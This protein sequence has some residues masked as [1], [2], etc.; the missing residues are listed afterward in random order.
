MTPFILRRWQESDIPA[1]AKYLN[2][3]KIFGTT[4]GTACHILILPKMLPHSYNMSN[5][6]TYRIII[7]LKSMRKLLEI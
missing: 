4:A 7:V 6:K 5:L 2:N 3:K 1:L